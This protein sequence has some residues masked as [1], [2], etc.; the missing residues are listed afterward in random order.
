M[1]RALDRASAWLSWSLIAVGSAL[2]LDQI[3]T[4]WEP[5]REHDLWTVVLGIGLVVRGT[6]RRRSPVLTDEEMETL[7]RE[8]WDKFMEDERETDDGNG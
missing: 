2:L 6:L 8:Q 4:L 5:L 1:S 7:R 3:T